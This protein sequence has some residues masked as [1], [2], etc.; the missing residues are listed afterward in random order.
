MKISTYPTEKGEKE[1]DVFH[2]SYRVKRLSIVPLEKFQDDLWVDIQNCKDKGFIEVTFE[3]EDVEKEIIE[4]MKSLYYEPYQGDRNEKDW[5]TF[6]DEIIERVVQTV[7]KSDLR[8][9][10]M[11]ELNEKSCEYI[12][13]KIKDTFCKNFLMV[14][15]YLFQKKP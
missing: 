4:W 6:Y 5:K 11:Q 9:R 3:D 12:L 15:P 10:A 13:S 1:F 7:L 14:P 2:P 8:K